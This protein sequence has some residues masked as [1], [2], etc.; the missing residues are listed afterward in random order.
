MQSAKE[1]SEQQ[2]LPKIN[3]ILLPIVAFPKN[4]TA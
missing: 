2:L 1:L 4:R 3:P